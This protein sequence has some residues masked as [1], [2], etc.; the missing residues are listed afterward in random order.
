MSTSTPN[1]R[2]TH[3]GQS[4]P[5]TDATSASPS[6]AATPPTGPD[7]RR[8]EDA[9]LNEDAVLVRIDGMHCAGC[10]HSVERSIGEIESVND[11]AVNLTT[12][13]AR[14]VFDGPEPPVDA[15]YDAVARA[16]FS[17]V[18]I[19]RD[20]DAPRRD[21]V[22][23]D[24][25]K[26]AAARRRMW[27]AWG[28]TVPIMLWML[29][30]MI[31]GMMW[32]TA[33]IFHL[34]MVLLATPVVLGAGRE[35][36]TS[37]IRSSLNRAP[38]MDVL[39][40]L[41]S[42]AALATGIAAT[43]SAFTGGPHLFDF[44]GVGAMIVAFH[45]TGRF[46]ET[47]A[48]G[49]ASEA[50]KRLLTLEART[51]RVVRDG[52]AVEVPIDEVRVGDIFLVQAG[53]KV[54][55]DGQVIDG[56]SEVD[57]SLVTGESMPVT[58]QPG[59]LVIGATLN[60][61][62]LLRVRATGVG[63]NTF[64][65]SVIRLVEEAQT[66]RVPIQAVADRVT[67][68]FVP[69]VLLIAV[70][71]FF[72]WLMFGDAIAAWT[73]PVAA[74]LPWIIPSLDPVSRALYAT[75]ATLVIACPCAL[76]LATPTAL[77]VGSGLGATSGILIRRGE[78]IQRMREVSVIAF[79]KTGTVTRGRPEVV[80]V[81]PVDG[82]TGDELLR[83][84]AAAEAGSEHPLA[85]AVVAHA[86][87]LGIRVIAPDS[88]RVVPGDGVV[89]ET[90]GSALGESESDSGSVRIHVGRPGF[91]IAAGID[92]GPFADRLKGEHPEAT[93]I[94]VARDGRVLGALALADAVR[95]S[96]AAA[97]G[98]LVARGITPVMMTGDSSRAAKA[99]G[100]RLGIPRVLAEVRPADKA[101]EVR[102][103][104]ERGE[105]V[106]MVG[107]GINDAPALAQADVGIAIGSGTDVAIE[108]GDIVLTGGDLGAVV[109]AHTL[110][111][112][113]F[114][115]I[116]QNLFWAFFYN[117][118]AIPLAMLG[119]LHP[120]IAEVAMALSSVNVVANAQQLRRLKLGG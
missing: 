47:R 48:R 117:V 97:I 16:G 68:V 19:D 62:G 59:D 87:S 105:V 10:V 83:A 76:G 49:R 60:A 39:I 51:A 109:R 55:T 36:L 79:D 44:S 80:D 1:T 75:I 85:K 106:A 115:K 57:E 7:G 5:A 53:E 45:L 46:V 54:P 74:S 8:D 11:V 26:L 43:W 15:L 50:I 72:A 70:V 78:A 116:R 9:V 94:W 90:S 38:N 84:A 2:K 108:A 102:K 63:R 40:A 107:D 113:T 27:I 58:K 81:K 65:A 20:E 13:T 3:G 14:V 25:R 89:A 104:Q 91:L 114:A 42:T 73:R 103:L 118:V 17:L 56:E 34:G 41:G 98:A 21:P 12:E 67:A 23:H 18:M 66:T 37:A 82:V 33:A 4:P 95:S 69:V 111:N 99:V 120:L 35:T 30:E 64:L 119:L 61:S 71:V 77:M 86:E 32:P 31:A 52:V 96:A 110:S 93:W 92:V 112:A 6:T 22:E 29:P 28:L 24:R 88:S 101:G 100:E